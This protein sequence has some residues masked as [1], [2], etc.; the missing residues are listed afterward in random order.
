[1][2]D[3]LTE[4]EFKKFGVDPEV[5]K[6]KKKSIPPAKKWETLNNFFKSK[7]FNYLCN[8][9]ERVLIFDFKTLKEAKEFAE[10]PTLGLPAFSRQALLQEGEDPKD[11]DMYFNLAIVHDT[12]GKKPNQVIIRVL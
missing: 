2:L 5:I 6:D 8:A 1:M 3:K 7:N 9:N 12:D 10:N 11:F 4:S